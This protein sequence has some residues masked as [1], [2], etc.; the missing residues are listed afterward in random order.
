MSTLSDL[1]LASGINPNGIA[2]VTPPEFQGASDAA[3][4]LRTMSGINPHGPTAN[5]TVELLDGQ[6]GA[7]QPVTSENGISPKNPDHLLINDLPLW[8]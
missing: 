1:K 7:V 6:N 4:S 3:N 5:G 8:P 2:G